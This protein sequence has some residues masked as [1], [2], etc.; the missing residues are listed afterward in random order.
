MQLSRLILPALLIATA[1]A[2][3][4]GARY[5]HHGAVLLPD[6]RVTPGAVEPALVADTTGRPHMVGGHEA[7]LCAKDFRTGPWRR[8][9]ESLKKKAC[10]EY[11]VAKGCPGPAY[12]ID[13]LISLEIGGSDALA[14]LWPQPIAQA[15]TKDHGTEDPLPKLVC[16]GKIN[17]K[18]AQEC[19]S[20]DWVACTATVKRLEAGRR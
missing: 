8:V 13:H 19:I 7:N 3:T 12:E 15:R 18:A 9:D 5:R 1:A 11:G 16:S 14:N 2:Q 6:A 17:L 10:A 4:G 20:K